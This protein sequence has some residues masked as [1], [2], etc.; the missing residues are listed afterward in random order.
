M[1][2]KP[3]LINTNPNDPHFG[4]PHM[5][6]KLASKLAQGAYGK[7][8]PAELSPTGTDAMSA[9][10]LVDGR[11]TRARAIKDA[12]NQIIS[13]LGGDDNV[14]FAEM[15]IA[16]RCAHLALRAED[17]D[18]DL[19]LGNDDS[20]WLEAYVLVARTQLTLH[21]ALGMKRREKKVSQEENPT[22][23]EHLRKRQTYQS[24]T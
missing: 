5:E 8:L 3:K 11:T 19:I 10:R 24:R 16:R 15:E 17:L 2:D 4:T 21:K 9:L 14:S 1:S 7:E 6:S 13:D 12:Y 20:E 22:L 23:H 18:R